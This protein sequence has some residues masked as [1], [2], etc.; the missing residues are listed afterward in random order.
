M[1]HVIETFFSDD[2]KL[3][4]KEEPQYLSLSSVKKEECYA[5]YDAVR[6][7][8]PVRTLEVGFALGASS[9]GIISGKLDNGNTERHVVLD[10]FQTAYSNNVGLIA[11]ASIGLDNYVNLIE[12][13]SEDHLNKFYQD[14]REFDFIFID[15][16]HTI[17]QAVTDA[18]LADKI[19]SPGGIIAIHDSLLFS[20]AASVKYLVTQKGYEVVFPGKPTFKNRIR[21][22]RYTRKLGMWYCMNVVPKIHSSMIFLQKSKHTANP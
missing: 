9:V 6:M 22:I 11:L 15:G 18:F 4:S 14:K 1:P 19:L 3:D 7:F 5:L 21:Q 12:A 8:K 13:F 20:T 16:S 17:G 10:P 2:V